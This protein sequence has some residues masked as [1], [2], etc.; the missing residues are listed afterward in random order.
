M[1]KNFEIRLFTR[2][3]FVPKWKLK[4]APPV[5]HKAELPSLFAS[6]A[7]A[8]AETEELPAGLGN[9]PHYLHD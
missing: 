4:S 3:P 5:R 2:P 7:T 9:I 1:V 6:L 8:R